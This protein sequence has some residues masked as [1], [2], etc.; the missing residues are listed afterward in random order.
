LNGILLQFEEKW[1]KIPTLWAFVAIC[2]RTG[3]AAV[4]LTNSPR[5]CKLSEAIVREAISGDHPA[6]AA[7]PLA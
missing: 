4:I 2:Q 7:P 5:G 6:F 1:F 3:E